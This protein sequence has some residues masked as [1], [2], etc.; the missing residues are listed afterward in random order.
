MADPCLQLGGMERE[1]AEVVEQ[2]VAEVE[3]GDLGATDEDQQT[4]RRAACTVLAQRPDERP[5]RCRVV[6]HVDDH[7]GPAGRRLV[8]GRLGGS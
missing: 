7:A 6:G 3:V 1:Q 5:R 4:R 2:L 8:L